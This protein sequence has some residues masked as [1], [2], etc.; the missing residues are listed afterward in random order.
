MGHQVFI[1]ELLSC[2]PG[3]HAPTVAPAGASGDPHFKTWAGEKYDFHGVCD[4]VLV[5]NP[6]FREG[7]GMDIHIRTKRTRQWSIISSAAVRIGKDTFEM[8]GG[9]VNSYWLNGVAGNDELTTVDTERNIALSSTLS[10]HTILFRQENLKTREFEILLGKG[11]SIV[12][13]AWHE[14]VRVDM[15]HASPESFGG[16]LGLLGTFPK[17][18]KTSRD[19][20]TVIEDMNA[21]G[22]EWQVLPDEPKLFHAVEGPQAPMKCEIPSSAS[23]RRRLAS[24]M[25]AAEAAR[26]CG[27]IKN[28]D[29]FDMCVFDVMAMDDKDV[30]AAH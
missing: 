22:Q 21:F 18:I 20:A 19:N 9:E 25:N 23:L 10:G 24:S 5:Q 16:S 27:H 8:T 26:A 11:E 1:V 4:L 17:G 29:E 13:Q 2:V 30:S 14:M 15:K 28:K 12:L 7:L 6:T 3:T